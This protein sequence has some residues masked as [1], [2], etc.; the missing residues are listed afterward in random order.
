[1]KKKVT[2]SQEE[3]LLLGKAI[4][5]FPGGTPDRWHMIAHFVGSG[6]TSKD[7]IGKAKDIQERKRDAVELKKQEEEEKKRM[8][9]EAKLR[10]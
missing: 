7:V 6:K 1:M 3:M 8:V 9:E 10:L 2:W 4:V 5:K